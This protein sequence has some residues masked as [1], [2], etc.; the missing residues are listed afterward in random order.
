MRLATTARIACRSR[1]VAG[2]LPVLL[3]G[4][5]AAPAVSAS[6][7]TPQGFE[8][9]LLGN[10]PDRPTTLGFAP[11]VN[12][13][14]YVATK[15]GR[16]WVFQNGSYLNPPFLDIRS[17]VNDGGENGLLGFVFDPDFQTNGH[18]YVAF[19]TGAGSGDSMISRFTVPQGSLNAADPNSE[20]IIWGPIPQQ[21]MGHKGGDLEFGTDGMLYHS[22]GDGDGGSAMNLGTA[23]DMSDPRG[24]V[25]RFDVAAPFP[26][27]PQN[28]PYVG[29]AGADPH[30]WAMGFRNPWRLEVDP[31][32]GDVY[33][34][35]VGASRW[36]EITRL[37]SGASGLNGGWPCMEGDQCLTHSACVCTAPTIVSPVHSIAHTGPGAYC[38][39]TG[40]VMYHGS[41]I[42]S[43]TG[44]LL[45][46]D[47]C[48]G[49]FGA[50]GDAAGT[51]SPV[52]ISSQILNAGNPIYSVVDF[53]CDNQ[54]EIYF[55]E[56]YSAK[57][58]KIVPAGG[59]QNYCQ[60]NSNSSGNPAAIAAS[61]SSS[62]AAGNLTL[63][64]TNLPLNT[65][66][67]FLT[68]NSQAFVQNFAGS[69]GN[70]CVGQ[71]LYRWIDNVYNAG[72]TG[73]VSR[74]TDL[75]DLPNGVSISAGETWNFQY[76]TRD[77]NPSVTSNTSDAVAVTFLP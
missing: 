25:L 16:I 35:D 34:A 51:P 36:E 37:P 44:H 74:T 5:G 73:S 48:T 13:R 33:V 21:T 1:A 14:M 53:A 11:G 54:G 56:H 58:W 64:V 69:D 2:L 77:S 60:T 66:G 57:I 65:F 45:Y 41:A 61:G 3:L 15:R 23:Q 7:A 19:T 68:A 75:T 18:F 31:Q 43:L 27:V 47:F 76:W 46:A 9:S 70:L 17:Q 38:S 29:T 22:I 10:T 28:N 8:A 71:P 32:S 20:E 30:I 72:S 4:F 55:V 12:D 26:H 63:T 50:L 52:D 6:P 24:K 49:Q 67:F 39:I 59:F 40:G 42:P 62:I